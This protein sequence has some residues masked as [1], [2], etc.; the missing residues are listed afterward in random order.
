MFGLRIASC[1]PFRLWCLVCCRPLSLPPLS[2]IAQPPSS[3]PPSRVVIRGIIK[4]TEGGGA[5][6]FRPEERFVINWPPCSA[7]RDCGRE[8][9]R[10]WLSCLDG[11]RSDPFPPSS[12]PGQFSYLRRANTIGRSTAARTLGPRTNKGEGGV[13]WTPIATAIPPHL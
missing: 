1:P 4:T 8:R 12:L 6:P 10:G 2:N 3:L 13:E 7:V 11:R 5:A 9:A